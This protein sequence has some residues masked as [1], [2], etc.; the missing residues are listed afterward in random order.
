MIELAASR[1]SS[2]RA[3]QAL[4]IAIVAWQKDANG[5]VLEPTAWQALA[6]AE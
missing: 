5:F 6:R 1:V 2:R 4:S 3:N